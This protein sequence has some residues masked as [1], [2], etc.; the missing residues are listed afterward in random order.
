MCLGANIFQALAAFTLKSGV[1]TVKQSSGA[2]LGICLYLATGLVRLLPTIRYML[3]QAQAR[4]E[5]VTRRIDCQY[6]GRIDAF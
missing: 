2:S 5:A 1:M 3:L 4:W 6:F